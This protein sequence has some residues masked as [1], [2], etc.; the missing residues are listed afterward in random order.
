MGRSKLQ[1]IEFTYREILAGADQKKRQLAKQRSVT[2]QGLFDNEVRFT[3]RG[4]ALW[5]QKIRLMD[6]EES[7]TVKG[8]TLLD[9]V[10]L[11]LNGDAEISCDCPS[12]LYHGFKYISTQLGYNFKE[13]PEGRFPHVMNP[14]LVGTACKHLIVALQTLPFHASSIT[15]AIKDSPKYSKYVPIQESKD[16]KYFVCP[17]DFIVEKFQNLG[18]EFKVFPIELLVKNPFYKKNS[19]VRENTVNNFVLMSKQG[20][21]LKGLDLIKDSVAEQCTHVPVVIL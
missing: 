15:K 5:T 8:A 20:Q 16:M 4:T 14:D 18:G 12:Y 13:D 3:S 2:F 9:R 6:L 1:L 11:A 10:R 7:L 17:E 19:Q 21:I